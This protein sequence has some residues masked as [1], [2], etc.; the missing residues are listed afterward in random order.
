MAQRVKQIG[1]VAA[2]KVRRGGVCQAREQFER[3][4]VFRRARDYCERTYDEWYILSAEHALLTPQQVIG[5]DGAHLH[6]VATEKRLRW[7]KQV[8]ES[9]AERQRQ[10]TEP[11]VFVLYASQRYAELL[12]RVAPDMPLEQPLSGMALRERVRWFDERLQ[13]RSRLLHTH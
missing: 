5:P 3:S 13:V 7:A 4:P 11:L 10:S 6:M 8:A 12:L 9:L 1:L 2:A